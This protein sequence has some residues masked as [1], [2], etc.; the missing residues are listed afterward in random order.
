MQLVP[1]QQGEL[2]V[3]IT[4]PEVNRGQPLMVTVLGAGQFFGEMVRDGT[5][6]SGGKWG[7]R[8]CI[9]ENCNG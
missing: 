3:F 8:T 9:M 4:T 5:G 2:N 1:P 6:E 7:R